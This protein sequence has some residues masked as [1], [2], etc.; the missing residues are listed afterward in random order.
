MSQNRK[1]EGK[2]NRG[3]MEKNIVKGKKLKIREKLKMGINIENLERNYKSVKK[4]KI[5]KK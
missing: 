3:K 2:L 4:S 5:E 1:L